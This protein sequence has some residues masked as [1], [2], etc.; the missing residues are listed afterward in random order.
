MTATMTYA[1]HDPE[2]A[3]SSECACKSTHPEERADRPTVPG[4]PPRIGFAQLL[5]P[6]II[7]WI[8]NCNNTGVD[9]LP[10]AIARVIQALVLVGLLNMCGEG[11]SSSWRGRSQWGAP[12]SSFFVQA[13][14]VLLIIDLLRIDPSEAQGL[15]STAGW[16]D[17][18][19]NLFG[20]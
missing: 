10:T 9:V 7:A 20:R 6:L 3:S 1:S 8:S 5:L 19:A 4:R 12:A 11:E 16:R 13:L 14:C 18:T 15:V 2:S 17:G